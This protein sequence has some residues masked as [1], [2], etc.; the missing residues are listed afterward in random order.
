MQFDLGQDQR[1]NKANTYTRNDGTTGEFKKYR[2]TNQEIMNIAK[3][4]SIE[5]FIRKQQ[6]QWIGGHLTGAFLV[7][8]LLAS[9]ICAFVP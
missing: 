5:N 8:S 6:R 9:A 4:E 1:Q 2:T 7:K 3:C